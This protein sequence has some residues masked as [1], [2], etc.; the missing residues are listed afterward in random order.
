MQ[1]L[2]KENAILIWLK[3]PYNKELIIDWIAQAQLSLYLSDAQLKVVRDNGIRDIFSYVDLL[4]SPQ[5][6]VLLGTMI[7]MQADILKSQLDSI[8]REVSYLNIL[9]LSTALRA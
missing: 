5:G 6:P 4:K 3:T 1:K 9:E 2:S 8:N 7:N